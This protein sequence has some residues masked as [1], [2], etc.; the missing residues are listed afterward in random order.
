MYWSMGLVEELPPLLLPLLL[1]PPL[2]LL[3]VPVWSSAEV[4]AAVV[5]RTSL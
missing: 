3:F 4:D 2:L 5:D 1:S